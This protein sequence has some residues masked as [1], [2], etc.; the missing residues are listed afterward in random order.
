KFPERSSKAYDEVVSA[1]YVG[2]AALQVGD[3]VHADA[4][5]AQVTQIV[6]GEPAGWANWGVL[7][8]R[9]RNLDT[10]AQ[11][12]ERARS[13]APDNDRIYDLLGVL[14]SS[15][16]HSAEAI[17]AWRKATQSNPQ[18]YRAAYH[19]AEEV[20]RQGGG[21]ADAE[22][23]ELIQK[24]LV[25]QPDNQAAWLELARV[26]AKRGDAPTLKSAVEKVAAKSAG[27]PPEVKQ[28]LAALQG[29]ASGPDP[30]TAATRT[31]FLRNVLMRVPEFRESLAVLKA[32]PGE[33]AEPFTHFVKMESPT[34]A[35][36]SADPGLTFSDEAIAG[37]NTTGG[38]RWNW[39]GA[40][41]LGSAGAPVVA[42]ANGREVRLANGGTMAFP[43]GPSAVPPQPEGVLQIDFN[44]D[45]K[46]DVVLAGAGGVRFLR[47][48]EPTK[49]VDV[50][51]QTRLP[52]TILNANYTA[53]WAVDIEADGDLD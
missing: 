43:G 39:L 33:E 9:Q 11:R 53:A 28:Q 6:P 35:P 51:A 19:L 20:E 13:T 21:N 48:D 49:F 36:A 18:N 15:R 4:K 3:D 52:K 17:A 34:F 27:W 22:F 32:A 26:A 1:F 12:F 16:G 23:Q 47:Q 41:A 31:I 42:M 44:Y 25:A 7:A 40:I 5:L 37:A 29:A 10:A 2:L 45:F 24:I 30:K 14:E 38:Q 50:T 8:L 46:T